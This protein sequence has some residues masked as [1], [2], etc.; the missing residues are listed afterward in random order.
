MRPARSWASRCRP[1]AAGY[2]RIGESLRHLG[3]RRAVWTSAERDRRDARRSRHR[4]RA[5]VSDRPFLWDWPFRRGAPA[6]LQ[7]AS[8]RL[9]SCVFR[10]VR[11]R[12]LR[13]RN[14][15]LAEMIAAGL[16]RIPAHDRSGMIGLIHGR[17]QLDVIEEPEI[18]PLLAEFGPD[19]GIGAVAAILVPGALGKAPLVEDP[20]RHEGSVPIEHEALEVEGLALSYVPVAEHGTA[21]AP[22]PAHALADELLAGGVPDP[23]HFARDEHVEGAGIARRSTHERQCAGG[24]GKD[25]ADGGAN[26]RQISSPSGRSA[27]GRLDAP[28]G[29]QSSLDA[30]E[31]ELVVITC[32]H[33]LEQASPVALQA[34]GPAVVRLEIGGSRHVRQG[35]PRLRRAAFYGNPAPKAR[36]VAIATG[37]APVKPERSRR[38]V[39]VA[40]ALFDRKR[41]L[42]GVRLAA[43]ISR[44]GQRVGS[45]RREPVYLERQGR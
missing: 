36:P 18:E 19:V 44:H 11:T 42:R 15:E 10:I 34:L 14:A 6:N 27:I 39:W 22:D 25:V 3:C 37:P 12:Q 9:G 38:V 32:R 30:S 8:R 21:L 41:N 16:Q 28:G 20:G 7:A 5:A 40:L 45:L 2:S 35:Q 13:D 33:A 4:R 29:A 1:S 17:V 43:V 26:L 23:D 31:R 24:L